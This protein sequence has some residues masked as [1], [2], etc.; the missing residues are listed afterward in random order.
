MLVV[1]VVLEAASPRLGRVHRL[2]GPRVAGP[3]GLGH[4]GRAHRAG[5]RGL[6]PAAVQRRELHGRVYDGRGRLGRR[7]LRSAHGR[8][9]RR[10]HAVV[11]RGRVR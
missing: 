4:A 7:V 10:S 9:R 1:G 3:H 2:V 11:H 8:R 5:Q 6:R